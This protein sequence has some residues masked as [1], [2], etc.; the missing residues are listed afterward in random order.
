MKI[1]FF[2][3]LQVVLIVLA[4]LG[5][6]SNEQNVQHTKKT[7]KDRISATEEF[8]DQNGK[9]LRD[10]KSTYR[11]SNVAVR[12]GIY[13]G[14]HGFRTGNG[15]PLPPKYETNDGVTMNFPSKIGLVEFVVGLRKLTGM[16][17][18]YGDIAATPDSFFMDSIDAPEEGGVNSQASNKADSGDFSDHPID[19]KFRVDYTGPLS[20]LMNYVSAQAGV[21]WEYRGGRISFLGARTVTY[22][23]AFLPSRSVSNSSIG[24]GG[25]SEVFGGSSPASTMRTSESDYWEELAKGIEAI[26]P[27]SGSRYRINRTNGTIILTAFGSIHRR[28]AEFV[29][30]E[31]AR[32]SR[33]VA[34][35][36]DVLAFS[37]ED[38]DHRS[39]SIN[40]L[41]NGLARGIGV[42]VSSPPNVIDDA[43]GIG[44]VVLK[45]AGRNV[46][47]GSSI[48]IRAL[49][50]RGK[51][52]LLDSVSVVAMN[53][54][55]TP[56]SIMSEQAYLAG[57]KTS[58]S[59]DGEKEVVAQT[60]VINNGIN[61]VVTPRVMNGGR[62]NLEYTLN[63]STLTGLEK[64]ET[65]TTAIQLPE[66]E[67]RNLMQTISMESGSTMVI[68]AYNSN[69]ST[70]K[71]SAPFDFRLWGF[72]GSDSAS[73]K[74]A[75]ILVL[76]TPV[77]IERQNQPVVQDSSLDSEWK[78]HNAKY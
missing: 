50:S 21:D 78:D 54:A 30:S 39:T 55:P 9:R 74:N 35:K 31:N 7:A 41:L 37:E 19:I 42:T 17:I 45:N 43:V 70:R 59:D 8:I 63:L 51:V 26:I 36:V 68:A 20:G 5:A 32:L 77:V 52:S 22:T 4:I 34:V 27:F 2:A 64:F 38:G 46:E 12:K 25:S 15:D 10:V 49:S 67:T 62:V 33:Q 66:V 1:Q 47:D 60:G 48:L 69:K 23:L 75:T 65:D 6:C 24:G 11:P 58:V 56:L 29:E 44:A 40:G 3:I 76:I 14:K 72:G 57:T 61:M 16:P 73:N 71:N 18:D 13:L 28:M 53:N